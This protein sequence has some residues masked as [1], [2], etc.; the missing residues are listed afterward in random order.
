MDDILKEA[1]EAF[2]EC[3]EASQ[4][5]HDRA[6]DD[7][8]FA[9]LGEQWSS[10]MESQ[11][12]LENRPVLTINKLS[13]IIRQVVNDSR[14]NKPS[15]KVHPVDS[16]SDPE[17][18][19]VISG[20]IRSIE[21]SSD[22]DVAYDTAVDSAVSGGF[23]YWTVNIE[24]TCDDS[25]DQDLAIRRVANPF[26]VFGDPYSEAADS[27]D[28]NVGF[29]VNS[30]KKTAFERDYKGAKSM[31]WASPEWKSLGDPWI[32]DDS[33]Q[34]ASYWKREKVEKK[35]V[36]LS[37]GSVVALDDYVSRKAEYDEMGVTVIIEPR[38]VPSYK[39]TQRLLTGCEE[40]KKVDWQGRYIP[41]IPVYGDEVNVEGKRH[42][43]SLIRDAKD[44]QRM[45]NYWRTTATEMVALAPRVPYIG[46]KGS[47][48]TDAVKW[49]TANSKSHAYIEFD[50]AEMPVRQSLPQQATAA[51]QEALSAADDI[52]SVTGIY[53]ASLGARSNETSG[54]AIMARQ[55]EGDVSTFHFI[56]NLARSIRHTGRVLIDLIP[57]VYSTER[58]IRT[59]GVDGT[60]EE[61]TVN[62][63]Y[64]VKSKSGAMETVLHDL[65][66]GKYDVTVSSGPSFT[67]RREEAATQMMELIRSFPDAA[68][69]IG[70]LIAKNLDWPG[71]D[72]VAKRLKS[73]LPQGIADDD[74]ENSESPQV[75]QMK[76]Q[77]QQM[78]EA[79]D[80]AKTQADQAT[81]DNELEQSK[82]QI[83]RY[84]AETNRLKVTAPAMGED[85]I[86]AVVMQ[87]VGDLL[88][89][90]DVSSEYDG[91]EPMGQP[92]FAE[93]A[94]VY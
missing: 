72:E 77:I 45:L 32:K 83:D 80:F 64:E 8:R 40:L 51:M 93:S 55:R 31:D 14:Q 22:A 34:L 81:S 78:Q 61:K 70:D 89:P 15:I 50:G 79:L 37:D 4:D 91:Q 44:P 69:M 11:R 49:A 13:P 25:F 62:A 53:D 2:A 35:I 63:P 94:E 10:Q 86:R 82:L 52:K 85:Q 74:E 28:W 57:K 33:I 38:D 43:R 9:R 65:T 27:S 1:Q 56:D 5:N 58:I 36:G 54:K 68:P 19:E 46:R 18:A 71:A 47:F 12:R 17:T 42:F 90:N 41:I 23:G 73:M 87:M 7:V 39:I 67:S 21:A 26:S 20:L 6:L 29:T 84:N 16:K 24:H 59:L 30:I 88:S 75:L 48:Q 66:V 60:Q 92:A 3:V 76:Q